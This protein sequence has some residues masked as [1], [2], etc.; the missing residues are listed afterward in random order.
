MINLAIEK[1][2][3]KCYEGNLFRATKLQIDFIETKIIVGKTLTN[4]SFWS[5]SKS[6][7]K[8]E[9]FLADP[10]RNILFKIKTKGNNIDI[11]K[12]GI[13]HFNEKEVLFLPYSKFLIKSKDK[14]CFLNKEIYEVELEGLDNEHERGNIKSF[15]FLI[16]ELIVFFFSIFFNILKLPVPNLLITPI[17]LEKFLRKDF[18][19]FLVLFL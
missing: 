1:G 2:E 18:W 3:I 14:K 17:F 11:H 16:I 8:A 13:S 4:L 9:Q 19:M 10:Y 12:E 15:S 5:S 7:E 6:K